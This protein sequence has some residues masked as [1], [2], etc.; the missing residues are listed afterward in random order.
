MKKKTVMLLSGIALAAALIFCAYRIDMS[1]ME[2]NRPVVFS[3]WGYDYAPPVIEED[4]LPKYSNLA[5]EAVCKEFDSV[6][7]S[8]GI[9]KM[10]RDIFFEYVNQFNESVSEKSLV[11]E[12]RTLDTSAPLYDPYEMQDEWNENNPDFLGY[13]CRIT[14]YSLFGDYIDIPLGRESDNNM[15]LFDLSA[16]EEDSSAF[17][18]GNDTQ[19]FA[20]LYSTVPTAVTK[21][22]NVHTDTMA[23]YRNRQG[24]SFKENQYASLITVVFH[25]AWEDESYLFIGHTGV[26]FQTEKG[27]YFVEKIAFQEPYQLTVFNNRAELNEYLMGK[28][29]V[30][31][32]WSGAAPFVM[33]N[34]TL[35]K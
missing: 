5:D 22:I 6:M 19:R 17:P 12:F 21:D 8:A 18:D 31:E 9:S 33:E 32:D 25:E 10:R 3:T 16:L 26:L 23:Q 30:A 20:T 14:S 1:R 2:H 15:I 35:M 11:D 4:A 24:I 13:N 29:D 34:N 28:Y 7:E 27:L